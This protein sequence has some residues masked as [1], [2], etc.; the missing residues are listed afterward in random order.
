MYKYN[1]NITCCRYVK[2]LYITVI[3]LFLYQNTYAQTR[4]EFTKESERLYDQGVKLYNKK[5]Y[6][7]AANLFSK[8]YKID[9]ESM[10]SLND[11]KEYA[12]FW[13]ASCYYKLGIEEESKKY[14]LSINYKITPVDR[15]Y[16]FESDSLCNIAEKSF[17]NHNYE[18]AIRQYTKAAEIEHSLLGNHP[19]Y[20]NT[21]KALGKCWLATCER[22]KAEDNFN[23]NLSIY[24]IAF[25]DNSIEYAE[26]LLDI[27]Y[28]CYSYQE[29]V[30]AKHYFNESVKFTS[31][32]SVYNYSQQFLDDL[33]NNSVGYLMNKLISFVNIN[34]FQSALSYLEDNSST[35]NMSDS[36]EY[37]I[38][39]LL[40]GTYKTRLGIYES[41][42]EDLTHTINIFDGNPSIYFVK[43]NV[44]NL[45]VYPTIAIC[46]KNIGRYDMS[47]EYAK[48]YKYVLEQCDLQGTEEYKQICLDINAIDIPELQSPRAIFYQ[49]FD[50]LVA[51]KKLIECNELLESKKDIF[52]FG[53][54]Q[55]VVEYNMSKGQNYYYLSDPYKAI[56]YYEAV[57]DICDSI[58]ELF[59]SKDNSGTWRAYIHAADIYFL[60]Q[61]EYAKAIDAYSRIQKHFDE[62]KCDTTGINVPIELYKEIVMDQLVKDILQSAFSDDCDFAINNIPFLLTQI[63]H[64]TAQEID[65]Y[66]GWQ[67]ILSG[68]YLKNG[69]IKDAESTFINSLN[70]IEKNNVKEVRNYPS[71]LGAIGQIECDLHEYDKALYYNKKA[72]QQCEERN[73]TTI[74]YAKCLAGYANVL[75]AKEDSLEAAEQYMIKAC[76][77]YER[78]LAKAS[79]I[80]DVIERLS[81]NVDTL[82]LSA[83]KSNA[84]KEEKVKPLL[85][86]Y[87]NLSQLYVKMKK[88]ESAL[89]YLD[90]ADR[91]SA[92]YNLNMPAISEGYAAVSLNQNDYESALSWM[93]K[94]QKQSKTTNEATLF[95][96]ETLVLKY[97]M[98]KDVN[99]N[100]QL[101]SQQL[102]TNI[103][104]IFPFLSE[105]Q[106]YNYWS[107]YEDYI[108]TINTIIF[109]ERIENLYGLL[110]DNILLSKN[111]LLRTYVSLKD[112]VYKSGNAE[113]IK[114]INLI[115]ENKFEDSN[116]SASTI[117]QKQMVEKELVDKYLS[118]DDI[119]IQPQT[120]QRIKDNLNDDE[121]AI[122]FCDIPQII[123]N[124]DISKFESKHRICAILTR[125]N[126]DFPIIVSLCLEDSL[127]KHGLFNIDNKYNL[128]IKP[129]EQYFSGVNTIYFSSDSYLSN[130]VFESIITPEGKLLSEL[131]NVYRLSSTYE[132]LKNN[133]LNETQKAVLYGGITY[134]SSETNS[135]VSDNNE[136]QSY[137]SALRDFRGG[138]TYLPHSLDEVNEIA[139]LLKRKKYNVIK[140]VAEEGSEQS[141]RSLSG[142]KID[143]LHI[144]T[145]GF[146]WKEMDAKQNKV[147]SPLMNGMA[148]GFNTFE[149]KALMRSGLLFA[150]VNRILNGE[151]IFESDDDGVLTAY[152]LSALDFSGTNLVVLSACETAQGMDSPEGVFGLQRGFKKAGVNSILMSL[153][154]I[155]DMAT[156]LFME[157]FY[158]T[159]LS[160]KSKI[161]SLR[162][163]QKYLREYSENG[164][165]PYSDSKYWA[166]FI[167]LDAIN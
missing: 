35:I 100:V 165:F 136:F 51:N 132:I 8:C 45:A 66:V 90:K 58:P 38:Y 54:P 48:K 49:E 102:N 27:A 142:N 68:C 16:T 127:L 83:Q 6:N 130:Y 157:K 65:N 52:D 167:L 140:N 42:I 104:S 71:V 138:A 122:E 150:G 5:K 96:Y 144:A 98:G 50:Y 116:S 89:E 146:Y 11:R 123:K 110:Y 41:A 13:L 117:S 86:L 88:W 133:S 95:M 143:I 20:G 57:M 121:I 155:D 43:E 105:S 151:K 162:D 67:T 19:W 112:E 21:L 23:K 17:N 61:K 34:D 46:Y 126:Y 139:L 145:H 47:L 99:D 12:A 59:F 106:R 80:A 153:W 39:K 108:P 148:S 53:N 64:N 124:K 30:L 69:A 107:Y 91:L 10:D 147:L 14:A 84:I 87:S 101:L 82:T 24:E 85:T 4:T 114:K 44:Q 134:N 125:K 78:N 159:Y 81:V 129:I 97:L 111:L 40:S 15:R 18:D 156:R 77:V 152:E 131:Y 118:I 158:Q 25:G 60:H 75:F 79:L 103:S 56:P 135:K 72:V 163:A 9:K 166:G 115:L 29:I 70:I 22:K 94:A 55:D 26:Q 3:A 149:D 141:L 1:T 63:P 62:Y 92:N 109:N 120:W 74:L 93:E 28:T 119:L 164:E 31:Y 33:Q 37:A 154:K 113:D 76:S 161:E 137:N 2:V 36:T 128:L 160:G 73:D 7:E 32:E